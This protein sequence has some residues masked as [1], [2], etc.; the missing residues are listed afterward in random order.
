[1]NTFS[2]PWSKFTEEKNREGIERE[3]RGR[4]EGI[5]LSL[6]LFSLA[7]IGPCSS[8]IYKSLKKI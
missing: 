5:T 4:R 8:I 1:M 6:S 7:M 3:N 2:L